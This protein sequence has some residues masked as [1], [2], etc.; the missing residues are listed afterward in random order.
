M[1]YQD[2]IS[3][4]EKQTKTARGV[5]VRCPAHQDG[6]A[7]LSV[8]PS[9]DGGVLLKCFAGCRNEDIVG[10]LGLKMR[11]LF[12]SERAVSFSAPASV[13]P[14]SPKV[15][16]EIEKVYS[17]RDATGREVYQALR[18]KPKSFR[19]RHMKDGSW[20]WT[21]DGVTRVLYRLPE[22]MAAQ[23][24]FV[25]E[26]EKDAD[27]LAALGFCATCN[28]GGAGKW[29]DGYTDALNGKDVIL[30]GDNDEPGRKHMDLVFESIAGSAKTVK[31][32]NL[33][34]QFK[35]VSDYI[36]GLASSEVAK[37]AIES[38]VSAAYPHV[39]GN[40]LPIYSI[41]ELEDDY[42]LFTRNMASNSFSLGKWLPTLSKIRPLVPGE[43]VFIIGDTGTGKTGIAQQIARAARPLPTLMFEIELP[44]ELMFERFAAM[45]TNMDCATIENIFRSDT[46][47]AESI[48]PELDKALS[49]I[50][51][52]PESKIT[53]PEIESYVHRASLKMGERPKVVIID[54]IQL[55]G[56]KGQS[57]RERVS[58]I[59]EGLK[60]MA[61]ATQTIV[62]VTSQI[63][64]PKED[65]EPGLHSAKESGSIEASCGLMLSAWRVP[66][67]A[68]LLKIRVLKSTK[69]GA[70]LT[71]DCNFDGAKMKI[72]ERSRFEP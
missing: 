8:G 10:A 18:M 27:S 33:P 15:R 69:G 66:D 40:K 2:F 4:F 14:G 35:D 56:G 55:I 9:A 47:N 64:R 46:T 24:V 17:Y 31:I 51:V 72:T 32:L 70:G 45:A 5:M 38:L 3:R 23:A 37:T 34:E 19:Q 62:I 28:V 61:K 36:A 12:A 20:V 39:R 41:A 71:I 16:P 13:V 57:R 11:D 22:V 44:K 68:T 52:C 53:L 59:A 65:E 1:T 54:Y 30:C 48:K 26:G 43:L 60:I 49:G 7:S 29:L 25:V 63:A 67:D 42:K 58:D 50:Y 6:S 21:M